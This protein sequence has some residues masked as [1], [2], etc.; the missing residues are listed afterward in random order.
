MASVILTPYEYRR[1]LLPPVCAKCGAAASDKVPRRLRIPPDQYV[2]LW[3]L[4]I[5]VTIVSCPPLFMVLS[6]LIAEKVEVRV[7][8]CAE[9]RDDW[10]W[11]D[12]A[13]KWVV[14][15]LWSLAAL[16]LM[17]MLVFDPSLFCIYV[18]AAILLLLLVFVVEFHVVGYG[19]VMAIG[20]DR[21]EVSLRR[22][23]PAFRDA[24]QVAREKDR[25]ENPARFRQ[26]GD[27]RDDYDDEAMDP[28]G[29]RRAHDRYE[30]DD[31]R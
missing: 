31:P 24:L 28:P 2:W 10:I 26:F 1:D 6:V 27:V 25:L 12:W 29:R 14:Y 11:R 23:H 4:P 13:Q 21:L 9:H 30:E 3:G 5:L 16:G 22:V 8:M 7:P 15:P 20:G 17:G 18:G 19:S